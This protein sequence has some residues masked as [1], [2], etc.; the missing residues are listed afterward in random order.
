MI[1]K[2]RSSGLVTQ[3]CALQSRIL[4]FQ[5][6]TATVNYSVNFDEKLSNRLSALN[7]SVRL[8]DVLEVV[9]GVVEHFELAGANKVKHLAGVL[10]QRLAFLEVAKEDGT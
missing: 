2:S 3:H 4:Q 8:G 1:D 10:V 7:V 6:D 9:G 5:F